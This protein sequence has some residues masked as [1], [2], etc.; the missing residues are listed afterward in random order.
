[1]QIG[2]TLLSNCQW[3]EKPHKEHPALFSLPSCQ[4][5]EKKKKESISLFLK[6]VFPCFV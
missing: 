6:T 3:A 2:V 4:K 1:M 5:Q